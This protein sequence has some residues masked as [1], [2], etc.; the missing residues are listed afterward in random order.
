MGSTDIYIARLVAKGYNRREGVDY[1]ETFSPVTKI[2]TAQSVIFLTVNT[3]W[4][5]YQLKLIMSSF[6][7]IFSMLFL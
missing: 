5:M 6:I 1:Q 3:S 7:V 2:I 4:P